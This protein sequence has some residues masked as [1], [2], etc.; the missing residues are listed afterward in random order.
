MPSQSGAADSP[1][2]A[3]REPLTDDALIR[4]QAMAIHA[5]CSRLTAGQLEALRRSVE[6]ACLMPKH[7][8]W[9]RKAT[10]HA[11]IFGLLADAA[12][13]PVLAQTLHSGAGLV[14]RLM[15]T[16]GP[17]ADMITANSRKR[18]L[19]LLSAD[20]PKGAAHEMERHLM[21]VHFIGRLIAC[22]SPGAGL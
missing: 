4:V 5:I 3:M 15:M 17:T 18:L 12:D 6:Q 11:E 21:T 9:D 10:A 19:A 7:I 14:H 1:L 22:P 8:G 16:A 20:D 13:H 2:P